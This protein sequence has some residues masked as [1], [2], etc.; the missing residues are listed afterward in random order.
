[1]YGR[2]FSSSYENCIYTDKLAMRLILMRLI[3]GRRRRV[4]TAIDPS[5]FLF[6]GTDG[7]PLMGQG[8][9]SISV[10]GLRGLRR[11][12]KLFM[13]Y[14]SADI[15]CVFTIPGVEPRLYFLSS[16]LNVVK[17]GLNILLI[18]ANYLA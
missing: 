11:L 15:R 5:N 14:A 2:A 1:M 10:K 12:T 17:N 18:G 8:F 3:L 6:L 4:V 13:Q 16:M 7:R 9:L